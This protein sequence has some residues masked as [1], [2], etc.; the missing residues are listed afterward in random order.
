MD[1]R[2]KLIDSQR[3]DG[4]GLPPECHGKTEAWAMQWLADNFPCTLLRYIA[5]EVWALGE[6]YPESW[7]SDGAAPHFSWGQPVTG[8]P[9]LKAFAYEWPDL[10]SFV[11]DAENTAVICSKVMAISACVRLGL[12]TRNRV[13]LLGLAYHAVA[14]PN[15]DEAACRCLRVDKVADCLS[16]L[17]AAKLQIGD[18]DEKL[19]AERPQKMWWRYFMLKYG[20]YS[21]DE[22][23]KYFATTAVEQDVKNMWTVLFNSNQNVTKFIE[24][25]ATT[26]QR[27]VHACGKLKPI[28]ILTHRWYC[29]AVPSE[30][31][32]AVRPYTTLVQ[33]PGLSLALLQTQAAWIC[34]WLTRATQI[35][36]LQLFIM[37]GH[38]LTGESN[39]HRLLVLWG[40][41]ITWCLFASR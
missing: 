41:H 27:M 29:D 13:I 17:L 9:K 21:V 11:Y 38:V 15:A 6:Y 23:F 3:L 35:P 32:E 12:V 31:W 14:I 4:Y 7:R 20:M 22:I 36:P 18:Y 33:A 30:V 28:D 8:S 24:D 5:R 40:T 37:L 26:V 25:C 2:Y 19:V 34:S 1:N 16:L 39:R 10:R